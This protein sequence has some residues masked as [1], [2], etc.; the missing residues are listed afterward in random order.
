MK[1]SIAELKDYDYNQKFEE[2]DEEKYKEFTK[3]FNNTLCNKDVEVYIV[4]NNINQYFY[5]FKIYVKIKII[6]K[7]N[8]NHINDSSVNNTKNSDISKEFRE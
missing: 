7:M 2:F 4:A 8:H 5:I 6:K 3:T 1:W